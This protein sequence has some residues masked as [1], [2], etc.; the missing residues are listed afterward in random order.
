M[1][2]EKEKQT[3]MNRGVDTVQKAT[4]TTSATTARRREGATMAARIDRLK[5]ELWCNQGELAAVL[6]VSRVTL[7][8]CKTGKT[9]W[10]EWLVLRVAFCEAR[11]GLDPVMRNMITVSC[12]RER[13]ERTAKETVAGVERLMRRERRRRRAWR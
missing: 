9:K 8:G 3:V 10:P 7:A 6:D 4:G 1:A 2:R 11:L 12:M 13:L 5:R